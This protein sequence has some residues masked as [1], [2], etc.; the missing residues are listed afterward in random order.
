MHDHRSS[1]ASRIFFQICEAILFFVVAAASV[2][3]YLDGMI[4]GGAS[5]RD[6]LIAAI[7][8]SADRP[9]VYR[10]LIPMAANWFDSRFPEPVKDRIFN[11]RNRVGLLLR[12]RVSL[13]KLAQDRAYFLRYWFF[14]FAEFVCAWLSIYVSYRL[15]KQMG[16]SPPA[17]VLSTVAFML[18]VPVLFSHYYDFPELLFLLLAAWMAWRM[19][20]LWLLPVSALATW[21]K[22]SF[23][24]FIPALYPLLRVRADRKTASVA[25]TLIALPSIAV[26]LALRMKFQNNPG[27]PMEFHLWGNLRGILNLFTLIPMAFVRIYGAWTPHPFHL[28]VILLL[29]WAVKRSWAS[30]PDCLKFHMRVAAL[31]NIPLYLLF[32]QN[33]ELRGLSFLYVSFLVVVAALC[34]EWMHSCE[35]GVLPSD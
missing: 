16:F 22:E 27:T 31:I 12:E 34:S 24:L 3:N 21:N 4:T 8:G 35:A 7:N 20:W 10:Q 30:L 13:A 17:A 11:S 9:F 32:G 1:P 6:S 14:C 5:G 19:H 15:C 28:F 25:T 18:L 33:G 2:N 23:L 29:I 26:N